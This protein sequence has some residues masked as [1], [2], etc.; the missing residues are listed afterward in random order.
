MNQ[1]VNIQYSVDLEQLPQEVSRLLGIAFTKL[2]NTTTDGPDG[3]VNN[4]EILSLASVETIS[5]LRKSLAEVDY[6]L[7]DVTNIINGYLSFKSR[8]PEQ[9]PTPENIA[10]IDTSEFAE[11]LKEFQE[12]VGNDENAD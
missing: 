5:T 11:K 2:R 6:M 4:G 10:S 9:A 3:V 1:R 8:P 7:E 12:L